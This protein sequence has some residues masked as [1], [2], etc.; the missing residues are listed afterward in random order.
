MGV[1]GGAVGSV[2]KK[3]LTQGGGRIKYTDRENASNLLL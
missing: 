3:K 2:G 1:G